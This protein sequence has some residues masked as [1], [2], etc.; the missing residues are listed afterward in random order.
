MTDT[1][2]QQIEALAEKA[3]IGFGP[4]YGGVEFTT[5]DYC[6]VML[7]GCDE[8]ADCRAGATA[9]AN[10]ARAGLIAVFLNNLPQILT[11][12]SEAERMRGALERIADDCV[13][14]DGAAYRGIARA[15]IGGE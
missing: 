2:S 12:L 5:T 8:V 15:A 9:E 6:E 13:H 14:V 7:N 1:L 10:Q 4:E 11:A 3:S